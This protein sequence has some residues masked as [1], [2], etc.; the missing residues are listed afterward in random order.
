MSTVGAAHRNVM[1]SPAMSRKTAAGSTFRRHTWHP[2][3]A[4]TIHVNVQPLAWNIGSVHRY[5]IGRRHRH[6]HEHAH[7][8]HPRVPVRDHHAFGP[9]RGA[10]RVVDGEQV[11]LVHGG[12]NRIT[13]R[14]G[15]ERLEVEPTLACPGERHEMTH[16]GKLGVNAV[17][18]VEILGIDA[19]TVAPLCS[20]RYWNSSTDRRKLI[21]TSTAPICGTA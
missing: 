10:A 18:G 19:H 3:T 1:P 8:V 14:I 4:V 6:V 20:I 5:A 2:P 7:R 9:R 15:D 17:D 11:A 12:E 16:A 21:G 13:V